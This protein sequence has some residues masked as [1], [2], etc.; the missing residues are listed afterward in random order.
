ALVLI[1]SGEI[2]QA[3][4]LVGRALAEGPELARYEARLAQ[5]E[6]AARR[7]DPELPSL[8]ATALQRARAGGHLAC[9]PRLLELAGPG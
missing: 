5:V 7:G 1:S 6:L 4:P 8:V 9:V 3:A 2:D